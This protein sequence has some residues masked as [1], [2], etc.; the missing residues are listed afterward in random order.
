MKFCL[1]DHVE[2]LEPGR[3]LVAVK[4]VS[5]AE[6]YLADHFP[7]FPVLPGVL[8]IE[9][10][11]QASAWLVRVSEDF[12]HSLILLSAARNVRYKSF[13]PPGKILRVETV[14]KEIRPEGS[15][16]TASGSVDGA[17][18][19]NARLSLIHR[20]LTDRGPQFA[21]MDAQLT[22][23]LRTTWSLLYTPTTVAG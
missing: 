2:S 9:A 22:A 13:V 16:F 19:V 12:A 8:M 11:T 14:V 7:T 1:I 15:D 21:E 17:E 23:Q 18:V 20:R 3:R 5:L 4:S 6:E 10:L